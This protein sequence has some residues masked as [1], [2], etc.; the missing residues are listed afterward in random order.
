MQQVLTP[1]MLCKKQGNI[2]M[3]EEIKP[4]VQGTVHTNGF[5]IYYEYYGS[6]DRPVMVIFNGVAMEAASWHKLV[7]VA[8]PKMDVLLW[9]YRGQGRSTS[10][11][12]PYCVE[13]LADGLIA[14]FDTLALDSK[15][16][17][18][19]GVSTGSIVV[20]ETLRRFQSRVNR[21][22]MSGV[23]LEKAMTFKL[24]SEFG[25]NM[26]REK[27]VDLWAQALYTKIF[28]DGALL[29]VEQSVPAMRD[30]LIDRYRDRPHALARIIEAQSN[31]LW[32]VEQHYPAFKKV[33][34]PILIL[35][36]AEDKLV[37]PFN[38]KRVSGFF[39]N[40]SYKEYP[41]CAHIPFIENFAQA[42][43][44]SISFFID[45]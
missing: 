13:E 12:V 35:A 3:S 28:S 19:V 30:A 26:L 10:D 23:L 37:P 31:Y 2:N 14:I 21:A 29:K 24:D 41:D 7:P 42:F 38:Q 27:R 1:G 40:A 6:K 39:P 4:A 8:F 45:Q 33:E 25:I 16:I 22:V 9:D 32:D 18:L 36:G 17:N 34:T 15:N 20:A 43:G 11:D 44:D 5:D